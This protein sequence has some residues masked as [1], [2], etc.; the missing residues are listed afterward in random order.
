MEVY[1]K[2][3]FNFDWSKINYVV[4]DQEVDK[5]CVL[6]LKFHVPLIGEG[7]LGRSTWNEV[8]SG[9][10][11]NIRVV[12]HFNHYYYDGIQHE[13]AVIVPYSTSEYFNNFG[14]FWRN[15]DRDYISVFI[16]K[17]FR[18]RTT[19]FREFC[20]MLKNIL[21]SI[22]GI[23]VTIGSDPELIIV[24]N[25]YPVQNKGGSDSCIGKDGCWSVSEIRMQPSLR[26]SEV[27]SRI[28]YLITQLINDR[29]YSDCEILATP[30]VYLGNNSY[31]L[32]GHI[33]V[34]VPEP[35]INYLVATEIIAH[36]PYDLYGRRAAG[37][38]RLYDFRGDYDSDGVVE[39]RFPSTY[40]FSPKTTLA[41]LLAIKLDLLEQDRFNSSLEFHPFQYGAPEFPEEWSEQLELAKDIASKTKLAQL[42]LKVVGELEKSS[43][44]DIRSNWQKSSDVEKLLSKID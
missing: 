23:P 11:T 15:H 44:V 33:H 7:Y 2:A 24:R 42:W 12:L 6:P 34:S 1:E 14:Y 35:K 3:W 30:I 37:Y 16:A 18:R 39:V 22:I 9:V 38:G 5:P 10:E 20:N 13:V 41:Y 27:Y 26:L 28:K 29:D 36:R 8:F 4:F 32:G 43:D 25:S 19:E 40:L 17:E 31:P 21:T